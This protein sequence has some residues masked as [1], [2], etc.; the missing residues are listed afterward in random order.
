MSKKNP[1]QHS[2]HGWLILDKPEGMSSGQAVGRLKRIYQG[3]KVG[4][5]GTLDPFACGV[6]PIALGEATK[7]TA[8]VMAHEKGYVFDLL[9]GTETD[10]LDL[11]GKVVHKGGRL[12][13]E[14]EIQ[15]V[16]STFKG[17]ILQKPP[18]FSAIKVSGQ[19]A[20]ALSR[21]NQPPDLPPRPVE[22]FSLR[23]LGEKGKGCW[24]FELFCGKGTYVRSLG[25][26]IAHALGTYGHLS[27][28]RRTKVGNF[29]E[30][31]AFFF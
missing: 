25:R 16:L 2:Y 1:S 6:L 13:T 26:D 28:L 20:Y 11:T 18:S 10:T 27:F 4:H 9:F 24:R 7:T 19:R 31:D 21:Q 30:K 15:E 5:G 23:C 12:P 14:E 29:L 22:I 17:R 3:A 8:Y